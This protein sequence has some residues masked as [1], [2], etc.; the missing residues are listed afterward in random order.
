MTAPYTLVEATSA[1]DFEL[2]KTLLQEYAAR[3]LDDAQNST[4]WR[5]LAE[6]PGRYAPPQGCTVLARTN[7]GRNKGG[8]TIAAC[9]AFVATGTDGLVEIKRVYVRDAFRRRGLARSLTLNLIDRATRA[10]HQ[11]AAISTWAHNAQALALYRELGFVPIAP[12]K[13]HTH[14]TLVFLGRPLP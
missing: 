8:D 10:G 5:D 14:A 4:I 11:T 7:D 3:D 1:A 2:V 9:A 12:F 13:E 6:W